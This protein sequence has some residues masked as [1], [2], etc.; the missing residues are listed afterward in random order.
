M[1][2]ITAFFVPR[3]TMSDKQK[4]Y[5]S[6][7]ISCAKLF[8]ENFLDKNY[9]LIYKDENNAYK[10]IE[11]ITYKSN[12]LHL[13]GVKTQLSGNEFFDKAISSRLSSTEINLIENSDIGEKMSV[14]NY[15]VSFPNTTKL[16]GY[17]SPCFTKNLYT[18]ILVGNSDFAL[19]FVK[20]DITKE[21]FFVPNTLLKGDVKKYIKNA[22]PIDAVFVKNVKEDK[23]SNLI[24]QSAKTIKKGLLS[25]PLSKKIKKLIIPYIEVNNY[26]I[27]Q[28]IACSTNDDI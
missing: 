1:N 17:F 19:G 21:K 25:L 18:E 20:D 12:Y 4:E 6:K 10:A 15:A 14:L 26:I 8:K 23:Y 2:A 27:N 16:T 5:I 9:L 24:H 13:T 28:K 3:R 11:T 22:F 7:I